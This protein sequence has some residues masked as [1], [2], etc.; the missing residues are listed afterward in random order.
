VSKKENIVRVYIVY[1]IMLFFAVSIVGQ[2]V[3]VQLFQGAELKKEANKMIVEMKTVKAPRGNI[4]AD[5]EQLT[6]LA[7]SVPRYKIYMDLVTVSEKAF[8]E[9]VKALSDSLG[10]VFTNK[11][12]Q[13]WEKD[14]LTQREKGNQYYLIQREVRNELLDRLRQFPIFELGKYKGGYIE[15]KENKR[16]KPYGALASRTI[17]YVIET[18]ADTFEVGLEGAYYNELRGRDGEM[19]MKRVRGGEWKPIDSD[20]SQEPIP[21]KDVYTSIDL[22]LQDVAESALLKQLQNQD[23]LRGCAVLMEVET[24]FVKAIA[25]LTRDTTTGK[26]YESSNM[27]VG[28]ASEPGSTFKLASLMVAL[29][30]GKIRVSDSVNM[31]GKYCFYGE[32]LHD[33]RLGGYGKNT[34]QYAFE[35]SSNV[36]SK[37]INDAYKTNPQQFI[38]GL[39]KIGLNNKLGVEIKG[40]GKPYIKDA[41]D[42]TFSGISLPWMSIGYEVSLTPLQILAFYNAVANEGTMVKPQFVKEIRENGDLIEKF[43]PIVLNP[44][45]CSDQT[46]LTLQ[47]LLEGV[48]ERGTARNIRARGFKIAGKTGTA[49]IAEDGGYGNKYQASFCGYFPADNPKYSCIVVVQ[50]PTKQIYGSVVSGTVFKEIADKVYAKSFESKQEVVDE[51]V[52]KMPYSKHGHKDEL[53]YVMGKMSVPVKDESNAEWVLTRTEQSKVKFQNRLIREGEMPNVMGMGLEDALYLLESVG[54]HAK[55]VGSGI[56]K[57]QSVDPGVEVFKGQLI[58]ITLI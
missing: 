31:N 57:S 24:G 49:K 18:E 27:A 42:T 45:V 34:I 41:S 46:R 19:L 43:D 48:V 15:L 35:K 14:L 52:A 9:N 10:V 8:S 30:D 1:V 23:A 32:C 6:S 38:N 54:L 44:K 37:I 26:Y 22:D 50:G 51:E 17:G 40:E 25:N 5:N 16:V 29:E 20:L 13:Q 12:A 28:V 53:E 39:K 2:I 7:L 36:I 55:V 47:Q 56:V 33:S 21:G 4:Y 11:S 3:R 58:T